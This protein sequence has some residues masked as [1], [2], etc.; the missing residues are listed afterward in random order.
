MG[1]SELER[2]TPAL[3][4]LLGDFPMAVGNV[5]AFGST[6]N[7]ALREAKNA[8]DGAMESDLELGLSFI[9][10]KTLPD[11]DKG[12]WA[13]ELSPRV[14]IAYKLYE[15]RRGKKKNQ[16]AKL[17]GISPQAYQRFETTKSS[18]S[19]ETLYRLA[20]ALGK[21]LVIDFV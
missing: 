18:P 5:N 3:N 21:Q 17:A 4:G 19:I 6:K 13:V 8:L 2:N 7:E 15:A 11:E 9:K 16:V 20:H 10:P 14:E 1:N 12:L